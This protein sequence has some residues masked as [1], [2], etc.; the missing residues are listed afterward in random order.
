MSH[1]VGDEDASLSVHLED[2]QKRRYMTTLPVSSLICRMSVPTIIVMLATSLYNLADSF[3]VGHLGTSAI[4]AVGVVFP[5]MAIIQAMGF[6]FGHGTGIFLSKA[7]GAGNYSQASTMASTGVISAFLC[8]CVLALTGLISA[9]PLASLCGATATVFPFAYDYMFFI[10]LG[11]PWILTSLTMNNLLRYHGSPLYGMIGILAGVILNIGLNP[12]FIFVLGLGIKGSAIATMVS[13]FLSFII[14][15]LACSKHEATRIR[16]A[17]FSPSASLYKDIIKGGMPSLFR[18]SFASIASICLNN[19]AALF[20][21]AAIAAI[22][23]VQRILIF[24]AS[25]ITGFGQGFQPVCGYNFGAKLYGRAKEAFFFCL[26]VSIPVLLVFS[27]LIF[28]FA[29]DVIRLFRKDDAELVEI[30]AFYI[31]LQSFTLPLMGFVILTNMLLQ[32]TGHAVKA[33]LMAVSRQGLFLLPILFTLTPKFGLLGMQLSQPLADL[34]AFLL[35][36]PLGL[37]ELKKWK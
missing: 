29:E 1:I 12:F 25:V 30:G 37:S 27:V 8:G 10:L 18:Q 2:I 13:Q 14:L 9:K 32:S 22:S 23:V 7:L 28:N 16:L 36:V 15:I 20:G 34:C 19:S 5:L 33:A 26:K 21:D 17:A 31:R 3:F 24:A 4:A 6:F 11:A 35:C